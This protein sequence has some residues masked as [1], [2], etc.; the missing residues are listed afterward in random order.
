VL[1]FVVVI[2]LAGCIQPPPHAMVVVNT[3]K[4]ISAAVLVLPTA[5]V[6]RS[7]PWAN[8]CDDPVPDPKAPAPVEVKRWNSYIDPPIRL[9]LEFAGFTLAEAGAM[10][11]VNADRV[12]K[13]GQ[14]EVIEAAAGARTVADLSFDDARGVARSLGIRNIVVPTLMI[15]PAKFMTFD[16]ELSIAL[17]DIDT[18]NEL[19]NV[20]CKEQLITVDE[21]LNRL[22]NCVGNGVLAVLAPENVIG[23]AL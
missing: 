9:K 1:R 22:A 8:I 20:H 13:D 6:N 16:A 11:L 3:P 12:D 19:W 10:R 2:A 21:T 14:S 4:P 7:G 17:V 18:G 5:C 15:V 23:K